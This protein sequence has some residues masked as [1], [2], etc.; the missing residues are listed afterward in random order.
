MTADPI[1]IFDLDGTITRNDTYLAYCLGYLRYRPARILRCW[2]LPFAVL[3]FKAGLRSNTWLKTT[4]LSAIFGGLSRERID[5]WAEIFVQ[6]VLGQSV[7][8]RAVDRIA[9]HRRQGHRLILAT[10]SLDLYVM[11]LGRQLG[12]TEI[13]ATPTAWTEDGR[14]TGRLAGDNLYGPGKLARVRAYL[15]A[16]RGGRELIVYSD[17]HADLG[18]LRWADRPVAVSPTRQLRD[19]APGDGIAVEFW[20]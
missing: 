1:V 11:S 10:A 15:G 14:L 16:D 4:F 18:L 13:L 20:E 12:F 3:A 8:R 2:P 6:D 19:A 9:E 5:D 7:R 17:H